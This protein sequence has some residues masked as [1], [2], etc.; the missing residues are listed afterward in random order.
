MNIRPEATLLGTGKFLGPYFCSDI[1]YGE[2]MVI[3][4]ANQEIPI[5]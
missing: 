4:I 2:V 3:L 1:E 5:Y